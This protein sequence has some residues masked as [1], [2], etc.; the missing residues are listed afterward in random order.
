MLRNIL[1]ES[2]VS[3]ENQSSNLTQPK[4]TQV[5]RVVATGLVLLA[6]CKVTQVTCVSGVAVSLTINDDNEAA[7]GRTAV[8]LSSVGAG[9][10]ANYLGGVP[11]LRGLYATVTGTATFDIE[12]ESL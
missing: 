12:V 7:S 1:N 4:T 9:Y 8:S 2:I 5:I 10:V 6:A 3:A 11:L